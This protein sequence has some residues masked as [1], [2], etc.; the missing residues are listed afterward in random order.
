MT[1]LFVEPPDLAAL[2]EDL[3]AQIPRGR[4]ATYGGLAEALGNPIA[5]RWVGHYML[6]HSHHAGCPCHRVVRA[7]GQVGL[8]IAGDAADKARRLADEGV[9]A[10][11][12][13]VDLAEHG[14][15]G[16]QSDRPLA[17]LRE[18]QEAV[19]RQVTLTRRTRLPELLAGVDVSYPREN[20]AVG[21]LALV[22]LGTGELAWSTTVRRRVVFPYISS[23]LTFREL[24]VL[25]DLV[26]AARQAG[27]IRGHGEP[28]LVDGSGILHPRHVGIA[29]H[30]GVAAGLPTVGVT[31]KLLVGQVDVEGLRPRQ[32]RPVVHEER[33]IGVAMRPTA[34]SRRPIFVSPGHRVDV[35]F[36][37]RMVRMALL[38]R[39]LP[40]PLH[41]ADRLSREAGRRLTAES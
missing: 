20:E 11:D 34:G 6:H 23:Y 35:A 18:V 9:T 13:R 5:A 2:L 17:R 24:P 36:A 26:E 16:F 3:L 10:S 33:A 37:E 21:A 4:V 22:D 8:Y 27:V 19:A 41:W 30:F 38:G 14:F 31:K 29:S 32:S 28:V 25:L 39:R 40:E 12:G 15:D 1:E 7:D